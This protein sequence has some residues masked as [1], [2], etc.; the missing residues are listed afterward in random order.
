MPVAK[1]RPF[2]DLLK[3]RRGFFRHDAFDQDLFD[4]IMAKPKPHNLYAIFFTPRSGSTRVTRLIGDAKL[5]NH[6][7]EFF[8]EYFIDQIA[9]RHSARNLREFVD[10]IQRHRQRGGQFGFE[11]TYKQLATTFLTGGRF[12]SIVKP[13][14]TAW[15]MREDIV[16]QAVSGSRLVQTQVP[17]TPTAD[18]VKLEKAEQQFSYDAPQITAMIKR[19]M[20]MEARTEKLIQ[21]A[22]LDTFRFSYEMTNA[23]G[24]ER[25]TRLLATKLG[26]PVPAGEV[27]ELHQKLPG[28]KGH[29]FAERFRVEHMAL[30][31][32]V[33][34]QR[35]PLLAFIEK[36]KELY[37]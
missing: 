7:G 36:Q 33:E 1:A 8:N 21:R 29:A 2:L 28:T 31:A 14:H 30:V 24:P 13:D 10:L 22:N 6:P 25:T 11:I 3:R 15:L 4:R 16:A 37:L 5:S 23:L 32:N 19:I 35:A 34:K 20:W 9:Q 12:L 27:V 18:Q 26:L 17:H